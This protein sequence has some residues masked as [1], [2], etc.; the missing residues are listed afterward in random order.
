MSVKRRIPDATMGLTTYSDSNLDHGYTCTVVD[1]KINH[2]S[3]RPH[4][5]LL[6][7]RIDA[8]MHDEQFGL[9]VDGIWG[10][11]NLVFPFAVYEAK[12]CTS[13]WE[14]AEDQVYHA[15]KVYLAMLDDLARD[16]LDVT[17]YQSQESMHYQLFG[18]TSYG[19]YWKVYIAWNFLDNCVSNIFNVVRH[20]STSSQSRIST[21]KQYGKA[22]SQ[23]GV[24]HMSSFV[25]WIKYMTSLL[26][27]I[28]NSSSN[29]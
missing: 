12:K 4:E 5:S 3:M 28:A 17:E 15:F 22:M 26:I 9:I 11:S 23:T 24:G 21:R 2:N 8:Q 7:Y 29:I 10:E 6:D 19:S 14:Q 20:T 1:C 25:S 16:P 18:F 13:T 27:S